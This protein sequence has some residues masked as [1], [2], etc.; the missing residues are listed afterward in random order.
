MQVPIQ[1]TITDPIY[2]EKKHSQIDKWFLKAINDERDLPF[3]Y[4]IIK[5]FVVIAPTLVFFYWPGM[6]EWKWAIAYYV[7][8]LAFLTGPFILML[9]NT[10]HRMLF[11]KNVEFLNNIIP[12][13][14]G[15]FFGQTPE[16]YFAHH[17]GMHH[18]E[19]NLADDHS[20]TLKYQRDSFL[21]FLKYYFTFIF[22][23]IQQLYA[24]LTFKKRLRIRDNFANGEAIFWILSIGLCFVNWQATVALFVI[25]V[26]LYRF[27]MMA[28]NWGQHAFVDK[29]SPENNYRN[30]ITCINSPYNKNCWN[31]GY[32][33]GHHL[34]QSMHWTELPLEFQKNIGNYVNENALVFKKVDFFAVWLFLMFKRYDW[35]ASF[36]VPL[37]ASPL[38]KTDLIALMKE[39]TRKIEN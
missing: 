31:D 39:R 38:A 30:S 35:L 37:T 6:F 4:L 18:P 5:L 2:K 17:I 22:A 20:S 29:N 14:L 19:N 10:S 36:Y 9:H 3:I 16:S 28:G 27:L 1:L 13:F 25:P 24:Y 8:Q 7:I 12:W 32:H 26:F 15:P 34:K 21:D 11:K 23:G 33:I